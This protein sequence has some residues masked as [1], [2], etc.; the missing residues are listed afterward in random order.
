MLHVD[1]QMFVIAGKYSSMSSVSIILSEARFTLTS[2]YS[3][4]G[5][6]YQFTKDHTVPVLECS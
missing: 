5:I 6:L 4:T 1:A 2:N 3:Q